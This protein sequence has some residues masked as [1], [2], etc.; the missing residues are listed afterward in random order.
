MV[1]ARPRARPTAITAIPPN[2][3]TKPSRTP[4]WPKVPFTGGGRW[5]LGPEPVR[6]SSLGS[7]RRRDPARML[8]DVVRGMLD[9]DLVGDEDRAAE[10][11]HRDD[12]D[13]GLEQLRR[14]ARVPD[15][16]P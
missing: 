16:Q 5:R 2:A 1:E 4:V 14:T 9:Q 7:V 12:R 8:S 11:P 13:V 10:M 3:A 15:L 6:R